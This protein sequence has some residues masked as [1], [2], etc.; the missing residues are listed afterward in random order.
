M[1]MNKS[2]AYTKFNNNNDSQN[3]N[4]LLNSYNQLHKNKFSSYAKNEIM[5]NIKKDK[6]YS[7]NRRI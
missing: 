1:I 5:Q 7:D 6:F 3:Y 4:L 2:N